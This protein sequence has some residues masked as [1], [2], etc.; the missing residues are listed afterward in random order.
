LSAIGEIWLFYLS[1]ESP[2]FCKTHHHLLLMEIY[3][4]NL[5][6]P[7]VKLLIHQK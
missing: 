2:L 1:S 5:Y 7:P 4:V 3:Y 6:R